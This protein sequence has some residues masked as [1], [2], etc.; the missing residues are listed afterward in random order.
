MKVALVTNNYK[1]YSGGVVSAI[2]VLAQNLVLLGHQVYI[3]TL[4]FEHLGHTYEHNVAIMRIPCPVRFKYKTN[5]IAIPWL[6]NQAVLDLIKAIKPDIIH[7]HHPFL[8]GISAA[9][10]G[11]KLNIPVVF[12]HHSQYEKFAHLVPLPQVISVNLIRAR[13]A[14]YCKLVQ[15]IIAPSHFIAQELAK[16]VSH[17]PIRVIPSG[18][19][20]IFLTP[21]LVFKPIKPAF[22]LLTVSR[23][24]FEK[25]LYFLLDM[26]QGLVRVSNINSS[27]ISPHKFT[28]VG[29]G[30]ELPKLKYY[31]YQQLNLTPNQVVFVEKPAKNELKYFYTQSDLFIFASQAETQGLVLAEAMA[32]GT[33]VVSLAGPGQDELVINGQNGFLVQDK[34]QMAQAVR[35]LASSPKLHQSMQ[36]NAFKTGKLFEPKRLCAQLFDF[37]QELI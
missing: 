36:K 31:A 23:F 8:L 16:H 9:K 3:I 18:I 35:L 28:L 21:K 14:D 27:S 33:P 15:G 25:N 30:P 19:L 17:I 7:A 5:H 20:P 6:P 10:A 24:A 37:Y 13:L 34:F 12:T 32:N 4:D 22:E 29:Y 1:P 2:D 11:K 26:F